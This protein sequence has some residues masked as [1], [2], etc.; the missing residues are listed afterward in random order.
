[1]NRVAC[2][3]ATA[4]SPS[5]SREMPMVTMDIAVENFVRVNPARLSRMV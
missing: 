2:R 4:K 5:S 1:M 3:L